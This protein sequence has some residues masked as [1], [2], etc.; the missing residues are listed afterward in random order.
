M[1]TRT[2]VFRAH[3]I[4]QRH[5]SGTCCPHLL[6]RGPRVL[7]LARPLARRDERCVRIHVGPEAAQLQ[8]LEQVLHTLVL[9]GF[10][11]GQAC[12]LIIR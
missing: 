10:A 7:P 6:E 8:L 1:S 4:V 11:C 2:P 5:S 12:R 3:L 9:H